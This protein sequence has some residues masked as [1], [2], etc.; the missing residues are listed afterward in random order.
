VDVRRV[1][2]APAT[3]QAKRIPYCGAVDL[4]VRPQA[5]P[6]ELAAL[7]IA[8]RKLAGGQGGGGEAY[9][10]GWRLA[11]L[12]ENVEPEPTAPPSV[13][14]APRSRRGASRA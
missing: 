5:T 8:L 4:D 12:L 3:P 10:S 1:E 6:E 13:A 11:G 9:R 14:G 2:N 7:T